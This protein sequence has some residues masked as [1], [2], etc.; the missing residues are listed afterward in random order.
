MDGALLVLSVGVEFS[1]FPGLGV[2]Q[3]VV[4]LTEDLPD[5]LGGFV[6]DLGSARDGIRRTLACS[7]P[8]AFFC[9]QIVYA[10]RLA[11]RTAIV[12]LKGLLN[13]VGQLVHRDC[14]RI[15]AAIGALFAALSRAFNFLAQILLADAVRTNAVFPQF[16]Y[17]VLF[18]SHGFSP[19]RAFLVPFPEEVWG[20]SM[21]LS[22][23]VARSVLKL[24]RPGSEV[25]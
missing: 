25:L 10:R 14:L 18:T 16:I 22:K 13:M 1:F 7:V 23:V 6:V 19:T 21:L 2:L 5:M 8:K 9:Q 20:L 17:I 4:P 11:R 15:P 3:V 12:L 24:V